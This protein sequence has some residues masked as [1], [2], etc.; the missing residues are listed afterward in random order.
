MGTGIQGGGVDPS[1]TCTIHGASV[2]VL[3]A[4]IYRFT[5]L[6]RKFTMY[7]GNYA[8]PMDSMREAFSLILLTHLKE[9]H[10]RTSSPRRCGVISFI[11]GFRKFMGCV[12]GF[13]WVAGET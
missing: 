1:S 2:H 5:D 6:P 11:F 9:N 8:N 12:L 7:V 4:K 13:F 10:I 3:T